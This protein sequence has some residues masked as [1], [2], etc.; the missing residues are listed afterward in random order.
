M[1]QVLTNLIGSAV[2]FTEEG[3]VVLR[4]SL[5]EE[6]GGEVTIRIEVSDT[7]IGIDEGER[8]RLFES[9]SQADASTTRKYGGT[10][11]GLAI[12]K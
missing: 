3:E 6:E 8:T 1:R 4:T 9:F 12:S 11:L 2:K 7:G 10:G 5:V